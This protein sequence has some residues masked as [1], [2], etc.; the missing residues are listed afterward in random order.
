LHRGAEPVNAP[1]PQARPMRLPAF[2][3]RDSCAAPARSLYLAV[4]QQARQAGFY[5]DLGVPDS[6]DGRFDMIALHAFLVMRRLGA[7]GEAGRLLAQALAEAFVEDM[8]RSLREMGAGDLGV[9]KRVQ[10]MA[11]GFYGRLAAYDA[12]LAA[13]EAALAVAL[14]R[15]LYGT[16]AGPDAAWLAAMSAYVRREAAALA[17]RPGADLL[18]GTVRFGL[19]PAAPAGAARGGENR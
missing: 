1:L 16:V 14:R 17:A 12:A 9:G 11:A 4:V 13:S 5:R 7:E 8:D 6:V 10:A 19:P 3:R 2:L 18:A 15:N